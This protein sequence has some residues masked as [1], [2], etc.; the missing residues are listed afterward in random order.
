MPS[1]LAKNQTRVRFQNMG[2][3][4]AN[5]TV[6]TTE[7]LAKHLGLSR[8]TISRAL[9][10]HKDINP[11]TAKKVQDA[12]A[13]LGFQP[14]RMAIALRGGK[15][16]LIGICFDELDSPVLSAKVSAL[17]NKLR[18][19]NYHGIIEITNGDNKLR[20]KVVNHLISMHIEGIIFIASKMA[21]DHPCFTM[22][23]KQGI[24]IILVDPLHKVEKFPTVCL[25]RSCSIELSLQHL[26]EQKVK[27]IAFIGIDPDDDGYGTQR[28]QN[29]DALFTK[30][31][32]P[33]ENI[34]LYFEHKPHSTNHNPEYGKS[35]TE[36]L[37]KDNN[38]PDAIIALNDRVAMGCVHTLRKAGIRV[39]KD[40]LLIGHD[41]LEAS[42]LFY[43][44]LT[45][46]E[47][48][49]EEMMEV[50]CQIL[51]Q[52]IEGKKINSPRLIEPAL[53]KRKSSVRVN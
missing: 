2:I 50:A 37:I 34:S 20:T 27:T 15:S 8:W 48:K 22:L 17:Q 42:E 32:I 23:E 33:K 38:L 1:K 28:W 4:K 35:L 3:K 29:I 44:P 31:K 30:Y 53:I 14:N 16:G 9:N 24:P 43:P 21:E 11:E 7:A 49:P 19:Q 36:R 52:V 12:C 5:K 6:G 45:T 26:M 25:D 10:G 40:I 51:V 47:Q 39:P 41:N 46:V 18:K 13:E